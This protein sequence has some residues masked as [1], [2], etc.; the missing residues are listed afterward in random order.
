VGVVVKVDGGRIQVA[1]DAVA[2]GTG[3]WLM[4]DR[5]QWNDK[6]ELVLL[7]RTGREANIG[8]KKVHPSEVE[9]ALREVDGVSDAIVWTANSSSRSFLRAA[10]ETRLSLASV[11]RALSTRLPEWKFPKQYL[12]TPE[13]PRTERGKLDMAA[14]RRQLE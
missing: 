14:L 7:G 11:Q 4:P 5:G 1:G 2:K 12:V 13:F 10:V 3:S 8:G 6:G 9:R